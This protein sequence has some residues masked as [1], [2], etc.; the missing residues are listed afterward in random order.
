MQLDKSN[1]ASFL[2]KEFKIDIVII[3]TQ[4]SPVKLLLI[5][6]MTVKSRSCIIITITI[7]CKVQA[8]I[9]WFIH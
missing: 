2:H 9:A 3:L 8:V 6:D 1:K 5:R 4:L 7:T